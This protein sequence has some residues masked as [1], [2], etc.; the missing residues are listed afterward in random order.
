M[1][2][3][4]YEHALHNDEAAYAMFLDCSNAY[5]TLSHRGLGAAAAYLGVR[6]PAALSRYE[7]RYALWRYR[8]VGAPA[9]WRYGVMALCGRTGATALLRYGV[10]DP[11]ALHFA[12][13]PALSGTLHL[14]FT[15]PHTPSQYHTHTPSLP[16][17][18]SSVR[19]RQTLSAS[20]QLVRPASV[21]PGDRWGPGQVT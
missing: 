12:T 1:R 11:V 5:D 20:V 19:V 18:S 3:T 17:P 9:L 4:E 2:C 10:I 8:L 7:P 21:R 14:G 13:P 16:R 6:P 15:P